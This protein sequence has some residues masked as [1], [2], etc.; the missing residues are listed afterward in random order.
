MMLENR[1][2]VFAGLSGPARQI[3]AEIAN[4]D[5]QIAFLEAGPHVGSG[6]CGDH[7]AYGF[8]TYYV[9]TRR[10]VPWLGNAR[11]WYSAA[12]AMGYKEGRLPVAG[13]IVV[14]RPGVDGVSSLGHVAYVEAV[15][16]AAGNPGGRLQA[17]G[18]ELRRL[19][20]R[21]TTA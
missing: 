7:F 12:A 2:T 21:S 17:L 11:D 9:A 20:P 8:C 10:C 13:A 19:E 18:D 1:N 5:N 3:A 15:G 6:P 14:F 4:I 16:P